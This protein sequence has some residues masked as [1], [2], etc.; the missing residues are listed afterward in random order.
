MNETF[1]LFLVI[2]G[3][4]AFL[5]SYYSKRRHG[6]KESLPPHF[7]QTIDTLASYE[8]AL[9][10]PTEGICHIKHSQ[11]EGQ[12]AQFVRDSCELVRRR[13][14]DLIARAT[15]EDAIWL[16]HQFKH[17]LIPKLHDEYVR[18]SSERHR[19]KM[20]EYEARVKREQEEQQAREAERNRQLEL[21]RQRAAEEA[22]LEEFRY[23][24]A[25]LEGV[26]D[27]EEIRARF[28]V[29]RHRIGGPPGP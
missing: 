9:R 3:F 13:P 27:E 29:E 5:I 11:A 25:V 22:A 17:V 28:T 1:V 16:E 24:I 4:F 14:R 7:Q 21:E 20:A 6:P 2:V 18:Y 19:Q 10:N 23:R 26:T 15:M 12:I 8:A